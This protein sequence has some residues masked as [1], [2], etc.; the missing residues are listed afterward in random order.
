MNWRKHKNAVP[1]PMNL[2]DN[3]TYTISK[4]SY[5]ILP[6]IMNHKYEND[7]MKYENRCSNSIFHVNFR[8]KN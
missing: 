3:P 5:L 7:S 6:C 2:S 8:G 4:Q 1:G